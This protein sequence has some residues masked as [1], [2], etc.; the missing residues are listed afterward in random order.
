M[1]S[2]RPHL[3]SGT[4]SVVISQWNGP[5][6]TRARLVF[7]SSPPPPSP[8][9]DVGERSR[10]IAAV[11][12]VAV[13]RRPS[14]RRTFPRRCQHRPA[15]GVAAWPVCDPDGRSATIPA[16]GR[17]R[18]LAGSLVPAVPRDP[19]GPVDRRPVPRRVG[20]LATRTRYGPRPGAATV[21][22][23]RRVIRRHRANRFGILT[24]WRGQPW[25]QRRFLQVETVS[26]HSGTVDP[27]E[28]PLCGYLGHVI[29]GS[30]DCVRAVPHIRNV[31]NTQPK[32]KWVD[33]SST[34]TSST[35]VGKHPSPRS[36][37]GGTLL[38]SVCMY[39]VDVAWFAFGRVWVCPVNSVNPPLGL[40]GIGSP[41]ASPLFEL[42]RP[43]GS[44]RFDN[45]SGD[46]LRNGVDF[47][48]V[49]S[50]TP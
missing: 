40:T 8:P 32:C 6:L 34:N 20:G 50:F 17:P 12:F 16:A 21:R 39:T 33:G 19:H 43:Q 47:C 36:H 25:S 38:V 26:L 5:V 24:W 7:S 46:V 14:W 29:F 18:R 4:A 28:Y 30:W 27:C 13:A 11:P 45:G 42:T 22:R 35:R 37:C 31:W 3:H 48:H 9:Y 15:D 41:V 49:D 10:A 44:I 1:Y 2:K 23:P